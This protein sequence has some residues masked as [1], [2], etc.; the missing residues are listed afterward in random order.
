MGRRRRA[1]RAMRMLTRWNGSTNFMPDGVKKL[2]VIAY[3]FPPSGSVG[4]YRTLKFV[5]YLPEFGWEPV[6]LTVSNG[7]F[8]VYD[9]SLLKLIP[10]GV[11]V[12]RC[13]SWETLNEGFDRPAPPAREKTLRS[14]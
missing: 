5:K 6:V 3:F 14:R 2:L 8:P 1:S 9:E 13:A 11:E 7:K 4:V 12:H 10:A